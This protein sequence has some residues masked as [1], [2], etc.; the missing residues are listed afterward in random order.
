MTEPIING[1][2]LL[3]LFPKPVRLMGVRMRNT[4]QFQCFSA[5]MGKPKTVEEYQSVVAK[6]LIHS[7]KGVTLSI[8]GEQG[9]VE[10][11]HTGIA[12]RPIGAKTAEELLPLPGLRK[13]VRGFRLTAA[14]WEFIILEARKLGEDSTPTDYIRKIITDKR[15]AVSRNTEGG[16]Y[17]ERREEGWEL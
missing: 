11:L 7:R 17:Q 8:F 4:N 12:G 5:R 1:G 15:Q 14:E 13:R 2:Y 6:L 10:V 3:S 9:E 16:A